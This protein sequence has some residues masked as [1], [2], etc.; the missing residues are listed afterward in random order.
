[1]TV[2]AKKKERMKEGSKFVGETARLNLCLA[3]A[4]PALMQLEWILVGPLA[5]ATRVLGPEIPV[6]ASACR[7]SRLMGGMLE[8]MAC[9]DFDLKQQ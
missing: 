7:R 4:L 8:T 6:L 1:M 5:R 2:R 3:S 9:H